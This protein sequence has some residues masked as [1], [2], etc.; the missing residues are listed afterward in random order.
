MISQ[1]AASCTDIAGYTAAAAAAVADG[2][3]GLFNGPGRMFWAAASER[4]GRMKTFVAILALEGVC[5]LLI[6]DV[7]MLCSSLSWSPSRYL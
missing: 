5:L 2:A 6:A 3:L 1:A 7:S 4:L